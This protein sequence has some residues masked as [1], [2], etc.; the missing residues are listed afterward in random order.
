MSQNRKLR[1]I[2]FSDIAGYTALMQSD[3][4]KA[5]QFLKQFK[6]TVE[7]ETASHEGEV[8]QYYGD[9]CLLSFDSSTSY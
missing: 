9:G 3:E 2:I 6:E 7:R 8:V 5:L 4:K 1:A